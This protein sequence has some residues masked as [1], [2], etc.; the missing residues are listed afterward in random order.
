MDDISQH[1]I[2]ALDEAANWHILLREAP[3]D[4]ALRAEFAIWLNAGA[5]NAEAWA[6]MGNTVAAIERTPSELRATIREQIPPSRSHCWRPAS[7][8]SPPVARPAGRARRVVA[9]AALAACLAIFV[10]SLWLRATSDNRT[11]TGQIEAV[12]LPD[13]SKVVLGPESAIRLD[14]ADGKRNVELT[15][16]QAFFEVRRDPA[17]PFE[18]EAQD[19]RTTVLGTA[20]DVRML[21]EQI[22]VGV[23][24]GRVRVRSTVGQRELIAGDWVQVNDSGAM[25][26]GRQ[27]PDLA[28]A[29]KTG[30][31]FIR[32]R[33]IAEVI[34]EIR[35]WHRGRILLMDEGLG[36]RKVTGIYDASNP[37]NA[38]RLLVD[39]YGGRVIEVTPWLLIVAS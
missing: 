37:A 3:D 2:A 31:A 38:L 34:D 33:P 24:H 19:V 6:A 13:G 39:P 21:G 14:F 15:S 9:A 12:R 10:P 16:G 18:V 11:G 20:F 35:P 25:Q 4:L 7:R 23:E 29:W 17:H 27:A 28:G 32:N 22:R 8:R 5:D 26:N 1:K 30:K 36:E